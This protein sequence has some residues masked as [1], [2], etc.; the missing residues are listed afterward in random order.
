M[1]SIAVKKHG[2]D[3]H[4]Y[5]NAYVRKYHFI[6][7]DIAGFNAV[8]KSNIPITYYDVPESFIVAD[9]VQRLTRFITSLLFI[10]VSSTVIWNL[11]R[12][13]P[14][15]LANMQTKRMTITPVTPDT[16]FKDVAGCDDAKLE[17]TEF[18]EFLKTP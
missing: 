17:V 13:G 12:K 14:Q 7:G 18:V 10:V 5:V 4:A 9:N 6:V 15:A 3:Y 1:R 2:G 8:V 16:K 11:I